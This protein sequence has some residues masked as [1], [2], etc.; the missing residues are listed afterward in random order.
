LQPSGWKF[1]VDYVRADTGDDFDDAFDAVIAIEDVEILP[2][3]GL[4]FIPDEW[5]DVEPQLNISPKGDSLAR[6]TL[7]GAKGTKLTPSDLAA[8]AVGG[9]SEVTVFAKPKVAFIPTGSELIPL[10]TLPKRGQSVDANSV[11]A[12]FMLSDMGAEPLLYPIVRD[13]RAALNSALDKLIPLVKT[14]I[15]DFYRIGFVGFDFAN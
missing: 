6:G 2:N 12:K 8:L 9:V 13:D 14:V 1:G 4:R 10:G 7:V 3:G 15:R 11:M 5:E